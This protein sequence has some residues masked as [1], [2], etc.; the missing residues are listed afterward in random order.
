VAI[1]LTLL[2]LGIRGIR[3]G[4]SLPAFVGPAVLKVLSDSFG[5]KPV[6]TPKEDL[7]AILGSA[8]TA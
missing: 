3:I 5:L 7:K 6:T 8:V 1:L 2:H 4:P